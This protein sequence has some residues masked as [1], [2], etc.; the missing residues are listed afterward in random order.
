[1]ASSCARGG[2]GWMLGKNSSPKEWWC[3]ETGCPGKWW[4]HHPWRC[5]RNV[6]VALSDVVS[7]HGGRWT[8]GLDDLSGLFQ[9]LWFCDSVIHLNFPYFYSLT[10]ALVLG[11]WGC[12]ISS[13][14]IQL[15]IVI[16]LPEENYILRFPLRH[17]HLKCLTF[18]VGL[19]EPARVP[20]VVATMERWRRGWIEDKWHDGRY[21]R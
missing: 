6:D 8:I 16:C 14:V 20:M 10:Q 9:P 18:C 3:T 17:T 21:S 2:S 11:F 1:M 5:P 15:K 19:R 13:R 12:T 7:R 4:S